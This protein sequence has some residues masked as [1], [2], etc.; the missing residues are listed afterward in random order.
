MKV[1]AGNQ[2]NLLAV[3][4]G[5]Q[6]NQLQVQVQ[7]DILD[8]H[9]EVVPGTPQGRQE[10]SVDWVGRAVDAEMELMA[11]LN[12]WTHKL[13]LQPAT[14]VIRTYASQLLRLAKVAM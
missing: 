1:E 12:H 13:K 9:K 3:V 2:G 8:I 7:V 11:Q 10:D 5:N 14:S 6:G 4:P